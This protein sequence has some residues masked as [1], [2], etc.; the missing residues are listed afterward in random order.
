MRTGFGPALLIAALSIAASCTLFSQE[1]PAL[2]SEQTPVPQNR[3]EAREKIRV[4]SELVVLS[5]MVKDRRGHLVSGLGQEEFRVFDDGVEQKIEIFTEEGL[6]LSLVVLVDNDLKWKEGAAMVN[7]LRAVIG[8]LSDRDEASVCRFDLLFYPGEDFTSNTDTL[9]AELKQAQAKAAP[10]PQYIPQP[11]PAGSNSTTGA[12]SIAAPTYAGA[13]PSKA[14][15]DALY[16][17][18]ALLGNRGVD[19]RKLIL[20]VSDGVNEPKLNHRTYEQVLETLLRDNISV[21]SLA[22]V[23]ESAKRK[24]ARLADYAAK[25]GGDI[26]YAQGS[27]AIEQLYSRITEEA[28]HEYTLAYVPTGNRA[29]SGYHALEVHLLRE[30]LMAKTREGYYTAG[31]DRAPKE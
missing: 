11:V 26:Y 10:E 12:P 30:G 23:N 18:A 29:D 25:S 4:N 16:S 22:L 2:P 21:Y 7:S 20:V 8:A 1:S 13:R 5:V 6:P 31:A 28:R 14:L 9:L 17:A 3:N 19:R 27:S 24:S 15:D